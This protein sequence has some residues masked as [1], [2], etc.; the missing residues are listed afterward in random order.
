ML[1]NTWIYLFT[2]ERVAGKMES[3][4]SWSEVSILADSSSV[5]N[6]IRS[7][8]DDSIFSEDEAPALR[9]LGNVRG[10]PMQVTY[11]D[12]IVEPQT[13]ATMSPSSSFH[14]NSRSPERSPPRSLS[15][16]PTRK[17][18]TPR[19][20]NLKRGFGNP[21]ELPLGVHDA[22]KFVEPSELF[23]EGSGGQHIEDFDFENRRE[24]SGREAVSYQRRN[25]PYNAEPVIRSLGSSD[26]QSQDTDGLAE[27]GSSSQ[28]E[29]YDPQLVVDAAKE[30][31]TSAIYYPTP[32]PKQLKRPP[33]L[34]VHHKEQ[35]IG[36]TSER[37]GRRSSIAL[38]AMHIPIPEWEPSPLAAELSF[39]MEACENSLEDVLD[40]VSDHATVM[41]DNDSRAEDFTEAE[42]NEQESPS[43]APSD[44]RK[45]WFGSAWEKI[46]GKDGKVDG[47][48]EYNDESKNVMEDGIAFLKYDKEKVQRHSEMFR[49]GGA[50]S[51]VIPNRGNKTSLIE[52]LE[53]RKAG[54]KVQHK[55][56]L[57]EARDIER[58]RL[59]EEDSYTHPLDR[60]LHPTLLQMQHHADEEYQN[61]VNWHTRTLN[62]DAARSE[63]E[64]L[65][66]RR[67]RLKAE[68]DRSRKSQSIH[69]E[70][71][72]AQ[73][74]ARL[75]SQRQSIQRASPRQHGSEADET[76]EFQAVVED[77]ESLSSDHQ[78]I[79]EV[80]DDI[81]TSYT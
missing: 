45:S 25:F 74:K 34:S 64:T 9:S 35:H 50:Y 24:T 28:N 30:N 11:T 79:D 38:S 77:Q 65:A 13:A 12:F 67:A 16:S 8:N 70:E 53:I 68:K 81:A 51:S 26:I 49:T 10:V 21:H 72:L 63:T 22:L 55:A 14:T 18:L 31:Q 37:P 20:G 61:R 40:S 56:I 73:R 75:R 54:R 33:L 78:D 42:G 76:S 52:E 7:G 62:N 48:R 1:I 2:I 39:S 15:R 29:S 36:A 19:P 69:Q 41:S 43:N 80:E 46:I 47:E 27:T 6:S 32:I 4:C 23:L 3:R 71:T 57:Y 60:T 5:P 17:L 44:K 66:E 58:Q 59:D